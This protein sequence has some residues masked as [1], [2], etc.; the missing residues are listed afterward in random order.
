[1]LLLVL[2]QHRLTQQ[3]TERHSKHP[4]HIG[5]GTVALR[6]Q[7]VLAMPRSVNGRPSGTSDN[8]DKPGT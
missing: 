3:V 4:R 7:G 1:M 8:Y 2:Q 5:E 6:P